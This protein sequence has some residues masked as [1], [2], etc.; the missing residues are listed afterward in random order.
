MKNQGKQ[1]KVNHIANAL[2][3]LAMSRDLEQAL[4]S[5]PNDTE[6]RADLIETLED[7]VTDVEKA[8]RYYEQSAKHP[9][10]C[11]VYPL[12]RGLIMQ[13]DINDSELVIKNFREDSAIV[14]LD[15][16]TW[17]MFSDIIKIDKPEGKNFNFDITE[18]RKELGTPTSPATAL[19]LVDTGHNL[20]TEGLTR[21]NRAGCPEM[22]DHVEAMFQHTD[23]ITNE[24]DSMN[25]ARE[26]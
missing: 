4:A 14:L 8:I 26:E 17:F 22:A 5:N 12:V 11:N 25:T 23:G 19:K 1:T 13:I 15:H 10:K 2:D 6:A 18:D 16:L 7:A 3:C 24:L 20:M 21:L 9:A